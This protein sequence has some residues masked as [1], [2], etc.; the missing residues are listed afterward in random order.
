M[1][2]FR[3][4][5]RSDYFIRNE[6]MRIKVS[7]DMLN[8]LKTHNEEFLNYKD[9]IEFDSDEALRPDMFR[10]YSLPGME[11]ITSKYS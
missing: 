9:Q 8:H 3:W 4:L 10:V 6:R 1:R 7:P 2:I 5:V 11:D